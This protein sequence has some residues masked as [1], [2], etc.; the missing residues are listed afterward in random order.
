ME[1]A[2][3]HTPK[4]EIKLIFFFTKKNV[5]NRTDISEDT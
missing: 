3:P 1:M 4:M 2:A 5:K